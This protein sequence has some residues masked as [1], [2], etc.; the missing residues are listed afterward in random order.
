[1]KDITQPPANAQELQ[2]TKNQ[3]LDSKTKADLR[4][5]G[6]RDR[7]TIRVKPELKEALYEFCKANGLSLCHVF[8]MLVS[9]YL[10]GMKQKIS[11]VSQSP[12]IELS[13]IREIKRMRRYAHESTDDH[14]FVEEAG[15]ATKCAYNCV[16]PVVAKHFVYTDKEHCTTTFVCSRHHEEL[17]KRSTGWS[18]LRSEN[19]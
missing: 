9:G 7:V 11:W 18:S 16:E 4:L 14:T 6:G 15:S 3:P 10:T 13:V 17:K 12:T 5:H 8:E 1:M 19:I 2:T